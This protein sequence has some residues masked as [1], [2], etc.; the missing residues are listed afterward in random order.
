MDY[1]PFFAYFEW[2]LGQLAAPFDREMVRVANI[3]YN[4]FSVVTY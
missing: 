2:V 3:D 4:E 1:P